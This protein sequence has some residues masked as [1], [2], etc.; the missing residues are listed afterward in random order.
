MLTISTKQKSRVLRNAL[1]FG[2][3]YHELR[4]KDQYFCEIN[5]GELIPARKGLN[6]VWSRAKKNHVVKA[7]RL[8]LE[9]IF[10]QIFCVGKQ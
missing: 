7:S 9:E 2:D 1:K 10:F 6:K 8:D 3:W 5:L 4:G